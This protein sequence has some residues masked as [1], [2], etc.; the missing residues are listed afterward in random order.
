LILHNLTQ[1]FH[2]FIYFLYNQL[3][4]FICLLALE[5]VAYFTDIVVI[6]FVA[7]IASKANERRKVS[8]K[9]TLPFPPLVFK[10]ILEFTRTVLKASVKELTN[11]NKEERE[12]SHF[13]IDENEFEE[14]K[15]VEKRVKE[16]VLSLGD[17][18][19]LESPLHHYRFVHISFFM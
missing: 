12:T 4:V 2:V 1:T 3:L 18:N 13:S 5:S 16:Y 10:E 8:G 19:A 9:N 15:K 14:K 7:Y 6:E 11:V 17:P